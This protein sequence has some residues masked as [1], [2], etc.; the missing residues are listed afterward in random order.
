MKAPMKFAPALL[1]ALAPLITP[2]SLRAT[3]YEKPPTLNAEDFLPAD[4]LKGQHHEVDRKVINDGY[5]N[6]YTIRSDFGIF[7]APSTAMA[8]KRIGEIDGI[9]QLREMIGADPVGTARG[10]PAGAGR[11]LRR[12]ANTAGRVVNSA[13][14]TLSQRGQEGGGSG[15]SAARAVEVGMELAGINRAKRGLAK[16]VGVDPYSRN[17]VL[18]Q[19][20]ERLAPAA[21]GGG[22]AAS[23]AT[24]GIPLAGQLTTVSSMVWDSSPGDLEVAGRESLAKM[25]VSEGEINAF[26]RAPHMTVTSRVAV[27]TVL[28]G[29]EGVAG[30]PKAVRLAS[31][32]RSVEEVGFFVASLFML[33]GYHET[34]EPLEMILAGPVMPWGAKADGTLALAFAFDHLAWTEDIATATKRIAGEVDGSSTLKGEELWSS[35][36]FSARARKELESLGWTVHEKAAGKLGIN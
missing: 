18:Q 6:H 9:A 31:Q 3:D 11:M 22:F 30:R 21:L 36:S 17:P 25:G 12:T 4:L 1:V 24:A 34:R 26:Y 8:R 7:E 15:D 27:V 20:L 32:L 10:V 33:Q 23:L 13:G 19:E 29:M 2:P 5:M 14:E 28:E 16:R 35:G